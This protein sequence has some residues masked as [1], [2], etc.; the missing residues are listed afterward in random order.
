MINV[1]YQYTEYKINVYSRHKQSF[2][3]FYALSG[4]FFIVG[5]A[6]RRVREIN[7]S[8]FTAKRKYVLPKTQVRFTSNARAFGPKRKC[9][10]GGSL[11]VEEKGKLD[12][13]SGLAGI[14]I[15]YIYAGCGKIQ[16]LYF[17]TPVYR[18]LE[19]PVTTRQ[20]V[21]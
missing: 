21:K 14:F 7:A 20:P 6:Y 17:S 19:K 15:N 13:L 16:R 11:K 2:G 8:A 1:T 3:R 9:V 10:F 4:R 12:G 18:K 5:Q